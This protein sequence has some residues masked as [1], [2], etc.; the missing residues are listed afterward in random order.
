MVNQKQLKKFINIFGFDLLDDNIVQIKEYDHPHGL[1]K[2]E[3]LGISTCSNQIERLHRTLN[4]KTNLNQNILQRL[5]IVI[6]ELH[7]YYVNFEANSRR[8]AIYLYKK[9]QKNAEKNNYC[10][11][12]NCPFNCNWGQIYSNR[13]GIKN[14]PCKH[15]VLNTNIEF[16]N[17]KICTNIFNSLLI[18]FL[19][20]YNDWNFAPRKH[21][22]KEN[23]IMEE[24]T[25]LRID[26][27]SKEFVFQTVSEIHQLKKKL[28]SKKEI[29]FQVTME[30]A[31]STFNLDKKQIL[32]VNFRSEFRL[33]MLQKYMKD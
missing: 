33:K 29:L 26:E 12:V 32:D 3:K 18:Q 30:W 17:I 7:E 9:M 20:P 22:K 19:K 21:T 24:C 23:I 31:K 5:S 10:G 1:W 2:R 6:K 13:F 8:Q 25:N 16:T 4:E 11:F 15:T 27:S 14:F 28:F